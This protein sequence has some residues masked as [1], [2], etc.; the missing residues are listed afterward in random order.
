VRECECV[1]GVEK[2]HK[3]PGIFVSYFCRAHA[4]FNDTF[5]VRALNHFD[6]KMNHVNNSSNLFL[7]IELDYIVLTDDEVS[8]D[9]IIQIPRLGLLDCEDNSEDTSIVEVVQVVW[10]KVAEKPK[11]R[12]RRIQSWSPWTLTGISEISETS[13]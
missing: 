8:E 11:S 7:G 13:K 12:A 4:V 2:K 6:K 1:R 3:S 9:E 5:K 10:K